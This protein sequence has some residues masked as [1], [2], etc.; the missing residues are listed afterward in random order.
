MIYRVYSTLP[1][2]KSLAFKPGLNILVA[3]KT[4]QSTDRQ[5]RNRAGK[6][7]L[8][9]IVHFLLGGECRRDS[10]FRNAALKEHRFGLEFELAGQKVAVERGGNEP[11][12]I[13]V[14]SGASDGWRICPARDSL[15]EAAHL[16]NA[17][18]RT[19][20]GE[21]TFGLRCAGQEM[22]DKFR[23]SFRSLFSYFARRE[24]EGGFRDPQ[25]QSE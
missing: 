11:S 18:W 14:V 1:T 2:F 8:V 6:S 17:N 25:R 24:S 10:I 7:S 22:Q 15:L 3:D 9:E 12:K 4:A 23:P 13:F 20:L 16:P 5:T 21:L 19:L